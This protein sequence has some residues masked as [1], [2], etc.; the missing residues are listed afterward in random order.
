MWD[1]DLREAYFFATPQRQRNVL[2]TSPPPTQRMLD[3]GELN[4]DL[5]FELWATSPPR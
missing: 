3:A 2:S 1:L 5:A 4:T